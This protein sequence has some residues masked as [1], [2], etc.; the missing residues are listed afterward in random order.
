MTR[1]D[2]VVIAW[3]TGSGTRDNLFVVGTGKSKRLRAVQPEVCQLMF[4]LGGVY[5]SSAQKHK[6]RHPSSPHL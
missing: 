6:L 2:T 1:A 3:S 4:L 5:V